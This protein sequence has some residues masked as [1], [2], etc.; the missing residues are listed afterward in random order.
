MTFEVQ[1][2]TF[3]EGWVNTWQIHHEDGRTEPETFATIEEARAAL[4]EFFTEIA[5]EI[6]AGQRPADNGYDRDD[7]R[8][9]E[10]G[11]S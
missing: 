4:D 1:Q 6:V 7:F 5:D 11:A 3:C 8:I 9:V 2:Y 10:G